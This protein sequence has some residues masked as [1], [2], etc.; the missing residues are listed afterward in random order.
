MTTEWRKEEP[1]WYSCPYGL[2]I[3]ELDGWWAYP[4]GEMDEPGECIGP[5]GSA[6]VAK[7]ACLEQYA[8][9]AL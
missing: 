8:Q 3:H 2:V 6:K 5:F 9:T 7:A 4:V 1:G